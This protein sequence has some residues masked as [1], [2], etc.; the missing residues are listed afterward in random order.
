RY[1]RLPVMD[2]EFVCEARTGLT[3]AAVGGGNLILMGRRAG[4]TLLA[5]EAAGGAMGGGAGAITPVS[6]GGGRSGS[7]GGPA[8]KGL[9]ASSNDA[10]CPTL[11]GATVSHLPAEAAAVLEIVIDG[12]SAEAVAAATRAGL[13]AAVALGPERGAAWIGAGNYGGNLGRHHFKL[14]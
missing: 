6:G 5:A 12:L 8:R 4:L 11:R 7:K 9:F 2:G 14:M 13:A 10:Y 3:R 1:W